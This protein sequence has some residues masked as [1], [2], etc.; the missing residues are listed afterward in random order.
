M[1]RPRTLEWAGP[2]AGQRA[3][4]WAEERGRVWRDRR[5]DYR[6][7]SLPGDPGDVT[8]LVSI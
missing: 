4:N 2:G 3:Q 6:G 5:A 8:R 1:A 7:R